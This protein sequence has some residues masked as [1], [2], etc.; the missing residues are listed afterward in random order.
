MSMLP[1]AAPSVATSARYRPE[2]AWDQIVCAEIVSVTSIM[3]RNQ[4]WSLDSYYHHRADSPPPHMHAASAAGSQA[5]AGDGADAA[6]TL[7]ASPLG[8]ASQLGYY[9]YLGDIS[10]RDSSGLE[11]LRMFTRAAAARDHR[12]HA[13]PLPPLP[14]SPLLQGFSKLKAQLTVIQNLRDL[15]PL[16]LLA[17]F[18]HVIKSGET[19]GHITGAALESVEKFIEY[20][21]LDPHH[22]DLP[23]AV[24]ALAEA[25]THCRFEGTDIVS[26]EV[27]LSRVLRLFRVLVLSDAGKKCIDDKSLCAMV[28]VAFGIHSPSRISEMLRKAAEET[29]VALVQ[30]AFERLAIIT[31]EREHRDALRSRS[32]LT[33][34]LRNRTSTLDDP[35]NALKIGGLDGEMSFTDVAD[36]AHGQQTEPSSARESTANQTPQ[37]FGLPSILEITRVLIS[38]IDP[39]NRAQ[40]DS[41]HR[42][43]G[44]RLLRRGLEVSGKS[45]AKWVS[46]AYHVEKRVQSEAA[47]AKH[48]PALPTEAMPHNVA[49]MKIET[50]HP[51]TVVSVNAIDEQLGSEG[52]HRIV[53]VGSPR[54]SNNPQHLQEDEDGISAES[55]AGSAE[56]TTGVPLL[57]DDGLAAPAAQASADASTAAAADSAEEAP[58]AYQES[59]QQSQHSQQQQRNQLTQGVQLELERMAIYLKDMITNDLCKS[60]FLLLQST[61]VTYNNPPSWQAL[62]LITQ[63]L[64]TILALFNTTREY[65]LPQQQWLIQFLIQRCQA[66]VVGWDIEDW[67]VLDAN[68][69]HNFSRGSPEPPPTHGQ[70]RVANEIVVGEVRELYLEALLQLSR[71]PTFFSELYLYYDSDMQCPSHL[72][73]ELI[74]FFAK[75]T[76]PD[77]TPGGPVTSP[78]HQN[79]CYDGLLLFLRRLVDRRNVIGRVPESLPHNSFEPR[80]SRTRSLEP[81]TADLDPS[82]PYAPQ[83]LVKNR[84]RKRIMLEGA[85]IFNESVKKGIKFFQEHGFLP[86]ELT[87]EAMANFL[88]TTP[89]LSKACIGEYFAKPDNVQTLSCYVQLCD[90][91][92]KRIDEALRILL[93]KF[94]IPGESQ[95]I[96]RIMDAFSHWYFSTIQDD[97]TREIATESDTAVLAFSVIMLNTDQHNKQVKRRMTFKDYS[98][99]VRGLNSGKD[100]SPEYLRSIYDAI[101]ATEI[102]MAEEQGGE[103]GFNF[104]WRQLLARASTVSQLSNRETSI[105]NRDMFVSV[106]G[107]ILASVFYAFDNAED[108][109]SLQ[110]AIAGVQHCAILAA[111]YDLP[112]VF[113]YIIISLL[114]MSGFNRSSRDLPVER[115]M[116]SLQAADAGSV[117]DAESAGPRRRQRPPKPDRWAIEIG[118]NYRGQVAAVLAFNLASDYGNT[119][120]E[121]WRHIISAIGNMFLHQ[122][123]PMSL[124]VGDHLA[125]GSIVIPRIRPVNAPSRAFP[126]NTARKEAGIFSTLSQLLSLG[127]QS[128][129]DDDSEIHPEDVALERLAVETVS[130]CRIPELIADT[131]FLEEGTLTSLIE[132][133][134]QAFYVETPKLEAAAGGD[135]GA[136]TVTTSEPPSAGADAPRE[137]APASVFYLELLFNITMRNRDRIQLLWPTIRAHVASVF[138]RTPPAPAGFIERATAFLMRLLLRLMHMVGR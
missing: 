127:S 50:E 134:T 122:V 21:V 62:S 75:S 73:E 81:P 93:E 137:F 125:Q 46:Y 104:Q 25:V 7:G 63:L 129:N 1:D 53:D 26:D 58:P 112:N 128:V 106:W 100:F 80:S 115:D 6:A 107:P 114:R 82:A 24:T 136:V 34:S 126:A 90:F 95:Q 132:S 52:T 92:G 51:A 84:E 130:A 133:L 9:D 3:R 61:N 113:D 36:P 103:L 105:Y 124:L 47:N 10:L 22:P 30:A 110:K 59:Q 102:V 19:N 83:T 89:N 54:I 42:L 77:A 32:P 13:G 88:A 71:S 48:A 44:L 123:L 23:R 109:M 65:M 121:S 31:K 37:P 94:R 67:A 16:H 60:L 78:I 118:G 33:K 27:V 18:L 43:L 49:E 99:N 28:E 15:D 38:L 55:F 119:I 96:E 69:F 64:K 56:D 35:I 79:L 97:P 2:L 5:L 4:R 98:K 57:A 87:P 86:Q 85:L 74:G 72:F 12:L 17:P 135:G 108:H 8:D 11:H 20:R 111:H 41:L 101:K 117:S 40:T 76:F 29:L 45:L 116:A 131:R 91:R 66:G 70:Q 120:R 39:K 14:E 68:S 138:T